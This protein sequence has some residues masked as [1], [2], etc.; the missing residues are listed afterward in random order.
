MTK[1]KKARTLS[2]PFSRFGALRR[3]GQQPSEQCATRGIMKRFIIDHLLQ[4]Y[5][6]RPKIG[7]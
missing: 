6:F 1:G 5:N 3:Q 4:E 2:K 7:T